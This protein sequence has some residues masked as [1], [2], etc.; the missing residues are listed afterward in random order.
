MPANTRSAGDTGS[1]TA[2]F[3]L[4]RHAR[5]PGFDGLIEFGD[6]SLKLARFLRSHGAGEGAV[7]FPEVQ[8]RPFFRQTHG[9]GGR[10]GL[11]AHFGIRDARPRPPVRLDRNPTAP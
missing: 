6:G 5:R 1:G 3:A 9:Q 2:C 7:A 10:L 11:H 8:Q 4:L